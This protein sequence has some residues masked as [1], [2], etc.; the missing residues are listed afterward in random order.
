MG[1]YIFGV[2]GF[3][4]GFAIGLGVINV[5]SRNYSI[6]DIK[7]NAKLRWIY[8]GMVWIFAA[9][10]GWLGVWLYQ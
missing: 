10:G 6:Q 2:L 1:L 9:I 3:I 7:E 8:G 5:L 4:F